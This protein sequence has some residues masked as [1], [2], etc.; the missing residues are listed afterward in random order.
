MTAYSHEELE[1]IRNATA[2]S[3]DEEKIGSV[4]NIYL[5]DDTG[6]ASWVS[7]N[8]GWFGTS[9]SIVSLQGSR[10]DPEGD[11]RLSYAKDLVKDA[12]RVADDGHLAPEEER[13]FTHYN[14]G[15]SRGVADPDLDRD[16][17]RDRD[18]ARELDRDRDRDLDRDLDVDRGREVRRDE[19]QSVTRSE[20][21]LTVGT[22]QVRTGRARLRKYVTTEEQTVTV[23]VQ[24]EVLSVERTPIADGERRGGTISDQGDQV[25]EIVLSE[26][27]P[28]VSKETVAVEE[29][30]V[31]KDVVTEE[32]QLTE[33][34][35]KEHVDV[36]TDGDT[37]ADGRAT[38][39]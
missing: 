33:Q 12:P 19:G 31:G 2:Y 30:S 25:E 18:V 4:G 9:Q 37:G 36:D 23:P 20:E 27:R 21:Q 32:H 1:R 34:V 14:L 3:V 15:T 8:T 26:E 16:A 22:E 13:L 11:L 7:V 17:A 10:L 39:R 28:V 24:K 38:R 6:E 35:A 29:V 5:D